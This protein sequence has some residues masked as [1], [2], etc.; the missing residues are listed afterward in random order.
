M[1]IVTN[2]PFETLGLV[3]I[4]VTPEDVDFYLNTRSDSYN[5]YRF[6]E[7]KLYSLDPSKPLKYIVHGWME[8]GRKARY[9]DMA[10][11]FLRNG[12]YNVMRVD[13]YK[14]ALYSYP[15]SAQSTRGVGG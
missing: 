3:S 11:E 6:D 8:N 13:W 9:K 15:A 10:E 1:S 5:D 12:D 4:P 2:K 14:P 7:S